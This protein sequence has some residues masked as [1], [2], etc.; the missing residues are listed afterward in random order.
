MTLLEVF[1]R[2]IILCFSGGNIV[3]SQH[4]HYL[5][6]CW[7]RVKRITNSKKRAK[8][9]HDLKSVEWGHFVSEDNL[10]S[11]ISVAKPNIGSCRKCEKLESRGLKNSETMGSFRNKLYWFKQ[12]TKI[13]A[14]F[15]PETKHRNIIGVDF[16]TGLRQFFSLLNFGN[17]ITRKKKT[18]FYKN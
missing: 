12:L 10:D 15:M 11:C 16:D 4:D 14:L 1:V 3:I 13:L 9:W 2:R 5:F 7:V 6:F 8:D 18:C 17:F